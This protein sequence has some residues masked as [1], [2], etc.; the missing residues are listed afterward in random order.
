MRERNVT[1]FLCMKNMEGLQFPK[2]LH[3]IVTVIV[4]KFTQQQMLVLTKTRISD[5]SDSISYLYFQSPVSMCH[6]KT[7]IWYADSWGQIGS[8]STSYK[9]TSSFRNGEFRKESH[10]F[11]RGTYMQMCTL[12][13][14]YV[15][16]YMGIQVHMCMCVAYVYMC[17]HMYIYMYIGIVHAY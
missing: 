9:E 12:C 5:F 11:L 17:V 1:V 3:F 15:C 4:S 7:S 10:H 13:G 8:S 6:V 2:S 16:M 14:V